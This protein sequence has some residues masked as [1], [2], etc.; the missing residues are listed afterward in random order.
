[1]RLRTCQHVLQTYDFS[2][3]TG[4]VA[5]K[6]NKLLILFHWSDFE[7]WRSPL[8]TEQPLTSFLS[9]LHLKALF[10]LWPSFFFAFFSCCLCPA[11]L[12]DASGTQLFGVPVLSQL[13]QRGAETEVE[14]VGLWLDGAGET[15]ISLRG[16]TSNQKLS[17]YTSQDGN[18]SLP[19]NRGFI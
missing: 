8:Y 2:R 5:G 1:M 6:W 16:L 12:I 19:G 4:H 13:N 11:A 17:F 10:L 3:A 14:Q 18:R 15:F 7:T 9:S